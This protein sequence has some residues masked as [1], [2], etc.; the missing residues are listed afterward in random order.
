[1]YMPMRKINNLKHDQ[2]GFASIVI[3]LILILVLALLTVGFAQL[4]RREQQNA[5]DKQ[6]AS[7]A[8]YAA[9]SGVNDITQ[10]IQTA[11]NDPAAK[12]DLNDLSPKSATGP[13][14]LDPNQCLESQTGS[15]PHLA[16]LPSNSIDPTHGVSYSCVLLNLEPPVLTKTPVSANTAWTTTFSTNG[17]GILD[18][19]TINWSSLR[20]KPARVSSGFTPLAAWNSPAVLQVSITP[21][22]NTDRQSMIDNTFTA[23]LYPMCTGGNVTYVQKKVTIANASCSSGTYSVTING[24]FVPSISDAAGEPFAINILD[25]YDDSSISIS[26]ATANN[27]KQLDFTNA[28]ALV[29][30]TGQ[31][32]NVLKRIRVHVPLNKQGPTPNSTVEAQNICKRFDTAPTI[33]SSNPNGTTFDGLDPSCTLVP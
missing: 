7:Q 24:L 27:G 8:Y 1:M 9:E 5:L 33:P 11:I 29:D 31:A 15:D 16:N 22:K 20:N 3:T 13:G 19:L 30:V 14:K 21:L 26:N 25:Y 18:S 17:G 28:Q 6:L 32:K 2:A 10:A 23:Y 12:P 4:V